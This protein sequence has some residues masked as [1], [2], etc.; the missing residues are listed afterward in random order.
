V[1]EFRIVLPAMLDERSKELL[2]GFG[3]INAEDVRAE[4]RRDAPRA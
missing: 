1:V 2:R 4:W 3:A